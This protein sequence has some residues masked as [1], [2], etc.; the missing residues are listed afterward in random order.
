MAAT[1]TLQDN[2]NDNSIDGAKWSTDLA[3]GGTVEEINGHIVITPKVN[4]TGNNALYSVN[5]Y[6][7]TGS[8]FFVKQEQPANV[9]T[10]LAVTKSD[11]TDR[12]YFQDWGYGTWGTTWYDFDTTGYDW[13]RIRESG[14]NLYFDVSTEGITWSNAGSIAAFTCTSV[15]VGLYAEEQ[16][17][18]ASPGAAWFDNFNVVASTVKKLAALG[19]G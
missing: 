5:N 8:Y 19:V 10:Y 11:W 7:L 16:S 6:D 1:S 14:G 18:E 2:F 3:G 9:A 13:R 12:A 17:L 4:Q 15:F